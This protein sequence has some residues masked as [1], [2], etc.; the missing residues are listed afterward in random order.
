MITRA[1]LDRRATI[2]LEAKQFLRRERRSGQ[3]RRSY[4][5]GHR[6]LHTS[7]ALSRGREDGRKAGQATQ[8]AAPCPHTW[9]AL[10]TATAAGIGCLR[11]GTPW[12][13]HLGEEYYGKIVLPK[14]D[15]VEVPKK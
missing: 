13:T 1:S 6:L 10:R 3:D 14:N 15:P 4:T 2:Q 7:P 8:V 9:G 12:D 5:P 11:C